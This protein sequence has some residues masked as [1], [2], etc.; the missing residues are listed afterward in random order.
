MATAKSSSPAPKSNQ[1]SL[2]TFNF[3][4]PPANLPVNPASVYNL[5]GTPPVSAVNSALPYAAQYLGPN[6]PY[7]AG[8]MAKNA[9]FGAQNNAGIASYLAQRG[10]TGTKTGDAIGKAMR[11]GNNYMTALIG[12][13]MAGQSLEQMS[14]QLVQQAMAAYGMDIKGNEA[15]YQ[16]MAQAIAQELTQQQ[17]MQEFNSQ[18]AQS[19]QIAHQG[20]NYGLLGAGIHTLGAAGGAYLASRKSSPLP[21]V[22]NYSYSPNMNLSGGMYGLNPPQNSFPIYGGG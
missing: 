9:Q 15:M 4:T 7:L 19:G 13:N 3:N 18:L 8:A 22:S 5:L 1:G 17:N 20:M 10:M 16:N 11:T 14:S 21:D 2:P 12:G 6:S